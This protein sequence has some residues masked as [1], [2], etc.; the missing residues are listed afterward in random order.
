MRARIV[1]WL[2]ALTFVCCCTQTHAEEESQPLLI[3]EWLLPVIDAEMN[4]GVVKFLK[5]S[6]LPSPPIMVRAEEKNRIQVLLRKPR[7][8]YWIPRHAV[9]LN[10]ETVLQLVCQDNLKSKQ[11][12]YRGYAMRGNEADVPVIA[13]ISTEEEN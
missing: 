10:T 13:C 6:E 11:Q 5:R 7:G 4:N 12:E 8:W 9:R 1:K 2:V 3:S